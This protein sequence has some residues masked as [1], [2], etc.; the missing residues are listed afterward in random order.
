MLLGDKSKCERARR[1]L[2]R[3]CL[4]EHELLGEGANGRVRQPQLSSN[5]SFSS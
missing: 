5:A 3:R 4:V 1:Y 2:P